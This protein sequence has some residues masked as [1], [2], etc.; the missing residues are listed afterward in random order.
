MFF[1]HAGPHPAGFDPAVPR[2]YVSFFLIVSFFFRVN[3]T[4]TSFNA[5]TWGIESS[6][7]GSYTIGSYGI[8]ITNRAYLYTLA[9]FSSTGCVVARGSALNE[10][11]ESDF[12]FLNLFFYAGS[13]PSQSALP[14]NYYSPINCTFGLLQLKEQRKSE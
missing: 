10:G 4:F 9:E 5:S 13:H 6:K 7:S 12:N 2:N 3:D 14:A 11:W 8:R 1:S